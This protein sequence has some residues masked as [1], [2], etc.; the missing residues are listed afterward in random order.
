MTARPQRDGEAGLTLIEVLVALALFSLIGLAGF[1]MLD[2]ILRVQSGTEGRLERLAEIDRAMTVF[3]RDLQ[4]SDPATIQQSPDSLSMTRTGTGP[5][6]YDI[7]DGALQR[8][9]PRSEFAQALIPA[10]SDLRLRA[11]DSTGTWHESWPLE[12]TQALGGQPRLRAIE[13]R[14]ALPE[15]ALRRLVDVPLA[16]TP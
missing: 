5:L 10:G 2:N 7:R 15:G 12:Q 9:L 6:I 4:Q 1:S 11:L 16:A 3:T 14:L 8:R 13:M